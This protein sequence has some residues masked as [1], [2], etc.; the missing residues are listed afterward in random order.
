ME[1]NNM[2]T[3]NTLIN[4]ANAF[5]SISKEMETGE[6]LPL[7]VR[8]YAREVAHE[9]ACAGEMEVAAEIEREIERVHPWMINQN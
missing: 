5:L 7:F 2:K 3:M 8:H 4:L 6:T 9:L 1:N